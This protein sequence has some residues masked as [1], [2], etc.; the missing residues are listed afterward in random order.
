M[1]KVY[2]LHQFGEWLKEALLENELN[3]RDLAKLLG[4][5]EVTV[6]RYIHGDR[7]PRYEEIQKIMDF[8][9]YHIEIVKSGVNNHDE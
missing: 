4:C 3:Q 8:L 5:S 6:S 2:S 7:M 1:S 9:G